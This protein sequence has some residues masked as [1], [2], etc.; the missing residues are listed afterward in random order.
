MSTVLTDTKKMSKRRKKNIQH[1][2]KYSSK[3]DYDLMLGLNL[4]PRLY[5]KSYNRWDIYEKRPAER[6]Y[7]PPSDYYRTEGKANRARYSGSINTDR[8][9]ERKIRE[10]DRI[11]YEIRRVMVCERRRNRRVSLF[12]SGNIGKGQRVNK[13]RKYNQDSEIK[14]RRN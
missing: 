12:K 2:T 14:C 9:I 1:R 3:I 8:D 13:I 7:T 6:L 4:K 11:N 10:N 5:K